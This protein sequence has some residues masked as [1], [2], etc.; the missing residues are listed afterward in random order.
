LFE[1]LGALYAQGAAVDWAGFDKPFTRRKRHIPTYPFQRKRFWVEQAPASRSPVRRAGDAQHPLLGARVMTPLRETLFASAIT[2]RDPAW[3]ADHR[4]HGSAV[5][6]AAAYLDMA[7]AAGAPRSVAQ[8]AIQQA[9]ILADDVP[10]SLSCVIARADDGGDEF[11]IYSRRSD[12]SGWSLHAAGRLV[13]RGDRALAAVDLAAIKAECPM[14]LA[15][16]A[17]YEGMARRGIDYGASF[18]AITELWHGAGAA[19]ARIRLPDG[20]SSGLHP[21]HPVLLD[22]A[23]QAAM[24]ALPAELAEAALLPVAVRRLDLI[25]QPPVELWAYA[26]RGA[27][28]TARSE[29]AFDIS[30]MDETGAVIA[31]VEGLALRRAARESITGRPAWTDWLYREEWRIAP[32]SSGQARLGALPSPSVLAASVSAERDLAALSRDDLT[33]FVATLDRLSAAYML[34]ALGALGW[35]PAVGEYMTADKL[36]TRLGVID[37]HRRLIGCLLETLAEDRILRA[38]N[39]G[40]TVVAAP[41]ADAA[42][43]DLMAAAK[44]RFPAGTS[45]LDLLERCGGNLAGVLK[46]ACDP[47][48]LIYPEGDLDETVRF[49]RDGI[50]FGAVNLLLRDVVAAAAAALPPDRKLRILEIGAGTGGATAHLLPLLPAEQTEYVFTDVTPVFT[51]RAQEQFG[52]Y[53]F[54]DYRVL[55][56]DHDPAAQGFRGDAYNLVIAANVLHATP[57]L[58]RTIA[59]IRRLLAPGGLLVLLEGTRPARWVDLTFG[60]TEGWW[61]FSDTA[62]RRGHPLLDEAAWCRLLDRT[63][64]TGAAAQI[65]RLHG[66]D[67]PFR[68]VVVIAQAAA[69][70]APA[71]VPSA[72]WLVLADRGGIGG[73]LA[74][75][76]VADGEAAI[77]VEPGRSFSA[78]ADGS[79]TVPPADP[80]AFRQLIAAAR[81]KGQRLAGVVDLW[82]LDAAAP[83]EATEHGIG[84]ALH[85]VQ[86]LAGAGFPESPPLF[87]VTRGS[88]ACDGAVTESG[89]AFA[90]LYGLVKT[91]ALEHPDLKARLIDLDPAGNDA[92]AESEMLRAELAAPSGEIA[93]AHRSGWRRVARLARVRDPE[94]EPQRLA[95][96]E[97]GALDKLHLAPLTRRP[98][99]PDEIEIGVRA[100]GLNFLDVLDALGVLPFARPAGLGAECVG[101]VTAL[102]AKITGFALGDRVIAVVGEGA[103][104]DFVT[105]PA[106]LAAPAPRTLDDAAAATLPVTYL[107]AWYALHVVAQIKPGDRVLI[108]A[109]TGGTGMAALHIA[110]LAG[111]EVLATASPGKWEALRALGVA[112]PMNSRTL[113]FAD[114]IMAATEGRGV[115][116][117]LNSLAGE[118]IAKSLAVTAKGGRFLEIGKTNV[119]SEAE[120]AR[121]RADVS[122]R[123]IDLLDVC[124]RAPETVQEMFGTL[125][126]AV[127]AGQLPPLP[128][129][130]FP[131]SDAV[132]AFRQMQQARHIGKI[133]LSFPGASARAAS[134]PSLRADAT[135]LVTGGFGGLGLVIAGAMIEWGARHVALLGRRAPDPR[136]AAAIAALRATGAEIRAIIADVADE[137]ALAAALQ[138]MRRAMPPLR[139]VIHAAGTLDDGVLVGQ[140]LEKFQRVMA[141]KIAGAWA[142]HRLTRNDPLDL[143]V[144]FSS[145]ASILG[146]AGQANHAAANAF[147]DALAHHRHALGLPGL[148]INWGG[149]MESGAAASASSS[150]WLG[151][152]GVGSMS[153][154]D[155]VA[156]FAA[157]L[158]AAAAQVGVLVMDW[159]RFIGRAHAP[160]F[161]ADMAAAASEAEPTLDMT[162]RLRA[163]QGAERRTL[164]VRHLRALVARVLDME[165]AEAVPT[166]RG[167]FD[168][169]MDSLTSVELRNLVRKGLGCTLPTTVALD[170]PTVEA[171]ADHVLDVIFP[172][173]A[174][175]E[176]AAPPRAAT[177]AY[178]ALSD[179]EAE[180]LLLQRLEKLRY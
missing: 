35:I 89:L 159:P 82:P 161:L 165:S 53:P 108:H 38:A 17:F 29:A 179:H 59:H 91:T 73:A 27:A 39:G 86:A 135:Y 107:T 147:L 20:L 56:I 83:N 99:G 49:Y 134:V 95:L 85:L 145:V 137:A 128:Q 174:G 93:V 156:A 42:P 146:S 81:A 125:V 154:G 72:Y 51:R 139:G 126:A 79:F 157:I 19:L 109:A 129:T 84:A 120:A 162:D 36:V 132:Y 45:E 21:L 112:R 103:F 69:E 172:A 41:S 43:V 26:R 3:L 32:L 18:R 61:R 177:A 52:A 48:S 5:V 133:V 102:G 175:D 163:A 6:P 121:L 28:V 22:A 7:L 173:A 16:A 98:P 92:A 130:D 10:T 149:W 4:V 111:A 110:Q 166:G 170:Y 87:F 160:P 158:G 54:I 50:T 117:V 167:F 114:E 13:P 44:A 104:A 23:F 37:R 115:D 101:E 71:G 8:V 96:A 77:L 122:Y 58:E 34:A 106:K 136:A 65:A 33:A 176:P 12:E 1:A 152:K 150:Q 30:L 143:F 138:E 97:A 124:R 105:V 144:L 76:L 70:A 113:D 142:L 55:D 100:A 64:F 118:F 9:L 62:L 141:P 11:R 180:A 14:P 15:V 127:D 31:A 80:A 153:P 168:L 88:V 75:Q 60:L 148:S 164:L 169:G 94:S 78:Q 66:Q 116:I 57:D 90:A 123:L 74:D 68:Q 67:G 171:L 25:H 46:G 63:G 47:L 131:I 151:N 178:D 155:G 119:L 24:A 2:A 40:W 140:S